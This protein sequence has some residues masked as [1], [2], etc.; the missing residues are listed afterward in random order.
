M[1]EIEKNKYETSLFSNF[2]VENEEMPELI[3]EL[4][5][6]ENN[7]VKKKICLLWLMLVTI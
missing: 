7:Q 6:T 1:L 2:L 3:V 5:G 4:N